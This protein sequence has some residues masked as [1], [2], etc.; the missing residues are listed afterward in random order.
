MGN[1]IVI[2]ADGTCTVYG[3]LAHKLWNYGK[4]PY[5][6]KKVSRNNFYVLEPP[7]D[8]SRFTEQWDI[9]AA[10][11]TRT[12]AEHY[13]GPDRV[14]VDV[15]NAPAAFKL[16]PEALWEREARTLMVLLVDLQRHGITHEIG[17][18]HKDETC[19]CI[20]GRIAR[21]IKAGLPEV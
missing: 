7:C 2:A 15:T 5:P 19:S 6:R 9:K 20:R 11:N 21:A 8:D 10:Q 3:E 18:S 1:E 4:G 14:L 17:C 16:E 12:G 13:M